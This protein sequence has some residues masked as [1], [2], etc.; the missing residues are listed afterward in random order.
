VLD[1]IENRCIYKTP[2]TVIAYDIEF[3][4]KMLSEGQYFFADIEKE[5]IML[6]DAGKVPLA[7]RKLLSRVEAKVIARQYYE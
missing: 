4:I 6:Y 5:G 2:V 1:I 7:E 3:I